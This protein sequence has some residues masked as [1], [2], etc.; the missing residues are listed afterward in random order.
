MSFNTIKCHRLVLASAL[1]SLKTV[2]LSSGGSGD[3][4]QTVILP[5]LPFEEIKKTLAS[6]YDALVTGIP[7][8]KNYEQSWRHS[9]GLKLCIKQPQSLSTNCHRRV[10]KSVETERRCPES[11]VNLPYSNNSEKRMFLQHLS[12]HFKCDC[13][14]LSFGD[15]K[16]FRLHMK[17]VHRGRIKGNQE[18]GIR[19]VVSCPH[20]KAKLSSQKFLH[21]HIQSVHCQKSSEVDQPGV[22]ECPSCLKKFNSKQ[23]T[24]EHMRNVHTPLSCRE[25]GDKLSGNLALLKHQR[26][27]HVAPAIC[28][29]CGRHF[30]HKK[31]L[32]DH[33]VRSHL[34]EDQKPFK[35]SV[36]LCPRGFLNQ[37]QLDDHVARHHEGRRPYTCRS[38]GCPRSFTL[39]GTRKRHE[40]RDHNLCIDLKRGMR[41][42]SEVPFQ[43]QSPGPPNANGANL[44]REEKPPSMPQHLVEQILSPELV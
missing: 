9:V 23:S 14:H 19:S 44:I 27:S 41:S 37:I 24:V 1:P 21:K 17:T 43:Q 40:K 35:C 25:C 34:P 13:P 32:R 30:K 42:K 22:H 18:R 28:E 26:E 2:L 4:F 10:A 29:V 16:V 33:V 38:Q 6:I 7:C 12:D 5:H 3:D 31:Y 36:Q 20:C 39:S 8:D 11:S 15:K